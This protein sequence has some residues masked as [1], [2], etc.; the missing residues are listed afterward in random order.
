MQGAHY[1]VTGGHHFTLD[2]VLHAAEIPV[3]KD[4]IKKMYKKRKKSL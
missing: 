1:T 3:R 2:D 4:Q